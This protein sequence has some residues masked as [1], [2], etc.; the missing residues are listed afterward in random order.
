MCRL[1]FSHA[2][3]TYDTFLESLGPYQCLGSDSKIHDHSQDDQ[4]ALKCT[5]VGHLE[6]MDALR[7]IL[8]SSFGGH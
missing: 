1:A 4:E 8:S 7:S 2:N 6:E 5:Q 3:W